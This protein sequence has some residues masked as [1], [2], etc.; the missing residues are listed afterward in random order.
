MNE[1]K[2]IFSKIGFN[3]LLLALIPIILQIVIINILAL[4]DGTLIKNINV[5]TIISA[6]TNYI[7]ILPIFIL[8]MKRIESSDI[9]K[10]RL[11]IKKF[12]TYICIAMTLMW[13]GNIIGMIITTI[14]GN[15]VAND[16]VNP[17]EKLIQNSSIYINLLVIS[18]LAPIFE[19][20]F[21][22]K[23]LIDRTIKYGAKLSIL[24]SALLFALFHGNLS[25]FFYAFLL[26]GFF[27][28]IY[29]KTGNVIYSI[30]CHAIVNLYGSVI[31]TFFNLSIHNLQNGISMANIGDIAVVAF[32][33]ISLI[34]IWC[35][36]LYTI[37]KNYKNIEFDDENR[38]IYLEKPLRTV[39]LNPGMI[40]FILYHIVIILMSLNII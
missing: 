28:Y 31:S 19:E 35:I 7:I 39:F 25:Q 20:I 22:R 21:F 27:A 2:K 34:I 3:Y 13:I 37:F 10:E 29:I 17:I 14:I 1:H 30:I 24:L 40:L 12:I 26:G 33:I 16:V 5:Q 8:L 38:E 32:Y 36:G 23:L 9:S 18:I 11:G 15:T 4:W 6:V